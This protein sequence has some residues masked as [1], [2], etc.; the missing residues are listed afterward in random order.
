M[1]M[2]IAWFLTYSPYIAAGAL[3]F[4]GVVLLLRALVY[5][6]RPAAIAR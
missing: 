4:A 2:I 3:A 5:F 1:D 6:V